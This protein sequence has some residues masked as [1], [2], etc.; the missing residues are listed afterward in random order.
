M[1]VGWLAAEIAQRVGLSTLQTEQL[2]VAGIL[3]DVGKI[4]LPEAILLKP[5]PLTESERNLVDCHAEIGASLLARHRA[6]PEI[7]QA[8]RCH[9]DWYDGSRGVSGLSGEA[10]P[11]S[12]RI[13]AVA[14]SFQSMV[15][16]RPYRPPRTAVEAVAELRRCSGG[17]FDPAIV[18]VVSEI[19]SSSAGRASAPDAP[20]GAPAVAPVASGHE[21]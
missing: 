3:H 6:D 9:H 1:W 16:D 11:R 10:L 13:L 17:Q 14:D 18:E 15:E 12:A 4:G 19:M 2:R 20:E 21:H 5:G 8:I 7:Q